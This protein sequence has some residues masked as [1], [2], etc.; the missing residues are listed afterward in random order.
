MSTP[1][2]AKSPAPDSLEAI[3]AHELRNPLQ[4]ISFLASLLA[5]ED[6]PRER[7]DLAGQV[8]VE[9]QRLESM[10][11]RLIGLEPSDPT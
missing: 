10:F 3:A 1:L 4:S 7:R 2:P 5:V 8:Q 6:D 11:S 9:I